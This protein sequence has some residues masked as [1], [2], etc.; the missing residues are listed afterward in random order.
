MA[1]GLLFGATVCA[2]AFG[3][4]WTLLDGQPGLPGDGAS[5]DRKAAPTAAV[6]KP[7]ANAAKPMDRALSD[8]VFGP[9]VKLSTFAPSTASSPAKLAAVAPPA[10]S[11]PTPVAVVTPPTPPV[12]EEVAVAIEP[13]P[14]PPANPFRGEKLAKVE[15]TP[16]PMVP[17]AAASGATPASAKQA[18]RTTRAPAAQTTLAKTEPTSDKPNFFERIF[19]A[20]A[21]PPGPAM[22]YARPDDG[23]LGVARSYESPAPKPSVGARTAVYDIEAHVVYMPDGKRLEAH[24]GLGGM[25]DDARY[26]HAKN[27]GPTPP[28]T[29][30]LTLREQLFHGVRAIR[31]NPVNSGAMFGR[32]GI[33]AHSFMLGPNG[34]S[35]G[36]VSFRDYQQFLQA[37]LRGEVNRLVV[38]PRQGAT[39]ASRI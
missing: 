27:R 15:S 19:G 31:L 23:A 12:R 17:S 20:P 25:I 28:N 9:P 32:D 6:A 1:R 38:V 29:Y 7:D 21:T 22:A 11:V 39:V 35:N 10:S 24:S 26:I 18:S 36:C 8:L 33:L 2:T 16:A 13:P 30:D 5:V 14:L 3:L 4:I 37:F 34:D